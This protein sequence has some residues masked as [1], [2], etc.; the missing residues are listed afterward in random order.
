MP[1]KFTIGRQSDTVLNQEMY[2][3][4]MAVRYVNNGP[5]QPI[6]DKQTDI[7]VGAIWND[8]G[9][10]QN[11]LKVKTSGNNWEPMFETYYHPADIK[12]KPANPTNGQLWLDED[13]IL[14][15]Y[16]Q[17]T[18][19][20]ISVKSVNANADNLLV[21]MH[22]N[23]I[24]IAPIKDMDDVGRRKTFLVPYER[25]GKLFDKGVYIHPTDSRYHVMSDVSVRYDTS[26][27]NEQESWIHV[28]AN[29]TFKIEKKLLKLKKEGTTYK[30]YGL[31]D[32]NTEFY[33]IDK[34][35]GNGIAMIPQT[36]KTVDYDFK[37][38]DRGI[39][40]VSEKAKAADYIY[41]ISY[42]FQDTLRAGKLIRNDFTIGS[43]S[44]I[45]VGQLTKRPMLFLDGLY[46]EQGKYNYSSSTGKVQINDVIVNPMDM[47]AVVF[48]DQEATG[49][50]EINN[51]TGPG[52]DTLVGTFT[53]AVNFKKPLAFVSG[54]MGTNIVSP[55]EIEWKG[56]SLL[57]KN[58]GPTT[59]QGPVKVMVVEAD[60]M[61]VQHGTVDD[62]ITIKSRE[63]TNNP[64][65]EYLLFIDGLLM[66]SRELD[67]SE[68]EIR[69][70][71]ARPGQQ[72]VLL[73]IKD[74][75]N[76]ALSF[77]N[78]IMNFTVAIS[79]EDGTMYNECD[80][81]VIFADGKMVP[82]EDAILRETLPIKG[83]TGQ[84][85]K[86]KNKDLTS[87]VYKYYEWNDDQ[88]TWDEI[89]DPSFITALSSMIK[90]T[91]SPGSIM[92]D[93]T[94]LQGK[95]GTFYA[96]TYSNGVEEPLLKGVQPLVKGKTVYSV[97]VEDMF[98]NNQGALT[99]YT[100]HLLNYDVTEEPSNTGKFI[101]PHIN[102]PEGTD[103]YD[104]GYLMYYVER[105]EKTETVS[106]QREVLT[107][108]NRTLEFVGGYKTSLSLTPGIVTLY[109]NGARL[110]RNQFTIINENTLVIHK[111]I[112]GSQNNFD[113]NDQRTWKKYI[114]YDKKGQYEIDCEKEDYI[115]VE[116]R[117]DFNIR[118][119]V[120]QVRYPGQRTFYM[121]DDGIPKSLFVTQDLIK[122]YIDG[123]VYYGEYI[124]NRETKSI[125]LLDR[126][127][128][129][130]L[131][132]DPIARFFETHP[133]EHEKYMMEHGRAY[134]ANP[135]ISEITFEWR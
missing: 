44:E 36:G 4:L 34:S 31:Y 50:K 117:Q 40:I 19:S 84:I 26:S 108:I 67:I 47:M 53:N 66:S 61:Y 38:F 129:N 33:Y 127:L 109:V 88:R 15:R 97:N 46:L 79:N 69:V 106:C 86:V 41:S 71:N 120:V 30:V 52:T 42:V 45:Q 63:V 60:N 51:V 1:R 23:F 77:D 6:K 125:T 110:N 12:Q 39:E 21:D 56:T 113:P 130:I 57:I 37:I 7:P 10:G 101:I 20:W 135:M 111:D 76:T 92:F 80:N 62:K 94:G 85:V 24:N 99:V 43:K 107:A 3:L 78:K 68:G 73:K 5:V 81:A 65:D 123:I 2:D 126:D 9:K 114:V 124:I 82:M 93:S 134:V 95:K 102:S 17:N 115:L 11:I 75:S 104:N 14:K 49:E 54:V 64:H 22:N 16:D 59:I 25:F 70:A 122:I 29:K 35:T 128:E 131:N 8:N 132:I 48:Q 90:G 32:N 103:A 55:D 119:Q 13:D 112:V 105:P 58:W 83:A 98:Q 27:S 18:A 121:E 116:V 133:L 87:D 89:Q 118:S 96:Y 100:N 72:Y 28:N 91:Y 74:D